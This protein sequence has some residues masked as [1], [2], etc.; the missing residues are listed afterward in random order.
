MGKAVGFSPTDDVTDFIV[1]VGHPHYTTD[2]LGLSWPIPA[3]VII[4]MKV[5]Q[6]LYDTLR[7]LLS[8]VEE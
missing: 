4:E 6:E 2:S 7:N 8:E 1:T 3:T 5:T